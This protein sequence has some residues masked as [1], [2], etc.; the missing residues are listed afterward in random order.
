[1][2]KLYQ[3][4]LA[5]MVAVA[6]LAA[7]AP[8]LA[9]LVQPIFLDMRATGQRSNGG[10]RVVNDRD[11]P[12]TVEVTVQSLDIPEEGAAAYAENDG[13]DFL[14]FPAIATIPPNGT[15]IFRVRWI[16]EPELAETKFFALTT[17]ELPIETSGENRV[18]LQVLYAIQTVVAIGPTN[19]RSD[20]S[21]VSA[22]RA[23][24]D[25]EEKGLRV[26]FANAG[27]LHGQASTATLRISVGDWR[28]ELTAAD[29]STAVGLGLVPANKRRYMFIP[30]ADLPDEGEVSVNAVFAASR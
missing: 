29:V 8:S 28:K 9:L 12:V 26:L 23:T 11:R 2:N 20:L 16:G 10:L 3:Y 17:S 6:L 22:E 4:G 13:A 25:K 21:V 30:V 5:A 7:A 15:Q 18:A 1:M 14:I 27:N 19:A 24:N